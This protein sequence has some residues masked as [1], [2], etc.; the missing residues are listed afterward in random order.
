MNLELVIMYAGLF[1]ITL[2]VSF[3]VTFALMAA[4]M[5]KVNWFLPENLSPPFVPT[6]W[7]EAKKGFSERSRKQFYKGRLE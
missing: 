3:V 4:L 5:D 2:A 7:T 6:I 1:G